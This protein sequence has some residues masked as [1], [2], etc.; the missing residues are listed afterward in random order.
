MHLKLFFSLF[1]IMILTPFLA[2]A[3]DLSAAPIHEI[4]TNDLI[5]TL[6]DVVFSIVLGTV[7]WAT[8]KISGLIQKNLKIN[9]DDKTRLY[10]ETALRSGIAWAERETVERARKFNQLKTKEVTVGLAVDYVIGRVPDGLAHLN[11]EREDVVEL[12]EAR[13]SETDQTVI[14]TDD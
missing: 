14:P 13:L 7:G 11:L 1:T 8:A 5:I 3:A 2:L 10:I 12:V 4:Q 6:I 9:I